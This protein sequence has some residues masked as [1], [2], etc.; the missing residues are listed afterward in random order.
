MAKS[1]QQWCQNCVFSTGTSWRKNLFGKK[2]FSINFGHLAKNFALL[3][4]NF[5]R[6][7]QNCILRVQRIILTNYILWKTKNLYIF[8][9]FGHWAKILGNGNNFSVT[10][11]K[12]SST[13]Q[14]N[15]FEKFFF[16]SSSDKLRKN[17]G[18]L[19]EFFRRGSQNCLLRVPKKTLKIIFSS[20]YTVL[21]PLLK[22]NFSTELW[23]LHC[24]CPG[25][26]L[27]ENFS[28]IKTVFFSFFRLVRSISEKGCSFLRKKFQHCSVG[29]VHVDCKI[30]KGNI[31][32][33]KIPFRSFVDNGRKNFI[34]FVKNAFYVSG[35]F[36][37][38][39]CLWKMDI[40]MVRSIEA[41]FDKEINK[42]DKA[43]QKQYEDFSSIFE[44]VSNVF[45][46]HW[47]NRSDPST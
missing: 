28:L 20:K 16:F 2:F 1:S 46:G 35:L 22:K 19:R 11:S 38:K 32:F 17:F 40:L 25:D 31:L 4:K 41:F 23:N 13:C 24:T 45:S 30:L 29:V 3:S 18:T 14:K 21:F 7:T 39:L 8:N 15:I 6:D 44:K 42:V 36:E 34:E 10:C 27:K 12:L 33:G 5:R 43:S 26:N 9:F 37:E 47:E